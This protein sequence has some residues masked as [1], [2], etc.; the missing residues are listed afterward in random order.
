MR[1]KDL[2]SQRFG[3]LQVLRRE[4]S[5]NGKPSWLCQCDCG[6][7]K[8]VRG[9]DLRSGH[10]TSC[11]CYLQEAKSNLR[12][13]K[14]GTKE[15]RTWLGIQQRCFNPNTVG[16]SNYG[17]RGITCEWSSFEEFYADMGD[18]PKSAESIDRVDNDKNYCR[19]NCKWATRVEQN[20]NKRNVVLLT[21]KGKTLSCSQWARELG[22]K[23]QTISSRYN[24]GWDVC[25]IL[26]GV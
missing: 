25:D 3:K 23:Q 26:K 20:N 17:G 11:G 24:K 6:D 7:T 12:H 5:L 18:C 14:C 9:S 22:L 2:T 4:G 16:Y 10:T 19:G 15:Y 8:I 1:I 21:Y 13:G